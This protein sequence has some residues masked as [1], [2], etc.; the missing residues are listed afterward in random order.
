MPK[1]TE[2]MK[3]DES[4]ERV[5]ASYGWDLDRLQ[6]QLEVNRFGSPSTY[7]SVHV[8]EYIERKRRIGRT[9]AQNDAYDLNLR[10]VKANEDSAK[11]AKSSP[12]SA[13]IAVGVSMIAFRGGVAVAA[14]L[15]AK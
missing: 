1:I 10:S 3:S 12:W 15:S 4:I 11:A 13:A 8:R 9:Q 6:R 7:K 5:M 2:D 14:L